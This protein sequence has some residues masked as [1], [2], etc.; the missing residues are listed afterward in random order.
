MARYKCGD[1]IN[2]FEAYSS[3]ICMREQHSDYCSALCTDKNQSVDH[4]GRILYDNYNELDVISDLIHMRHIVEINS[5]LANC[6]APGV[7]ES[8]DPDRWHEEI[9]SQLWTHGT[10]W[11]DLNNDINNT[12]WSS[13]IWYY[14]DSQSIKSWKPA[15]WVRTRFESGWQPLKR[16]LNSSISL[17]LPPYE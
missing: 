5:I 4:I 17:E 12:G 8:E 2:D 13:E 7:F 16:V 14:Y 9:G 6:D 1:N 15:W 11:H 3:R 10:S